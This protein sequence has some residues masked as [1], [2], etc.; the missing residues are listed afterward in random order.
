MLVSNILVTN[1]NK[2]LICIWKSSKSDKNNIVPG[3]ICRRI[4]AHVTM[5]WDPTSRPMFSD[6]GQWHIGKKNNKNIQVLWC[7]WFTL[8]KS[9]K[10]FNWICVSIGNS[11]RECTF[12][13][14]RIMMLLCSVS[15]VCSFARFIDVMLD[16]RILP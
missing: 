6:H 10:C 5:C 3:C 12:I 11:K 13:F 8:Y 1:W 14:V 16:R 15:S 7:R 9:W 2:K 4:Q